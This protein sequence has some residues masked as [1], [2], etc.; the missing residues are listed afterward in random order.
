MTKVLKKDK[1]VNKRLKVAVIS[2]ITGGLGHYAFHLLRKLNKYVDYRYITY[3]QFDLIGEKVNRI[4]DP[5]FENKLT[6]QPKFFIDS[7]DGLESL[8]RVVSYIKNHKIDVVNIHIGTT[9]RKMIMFYTT[10]ILELKNY[11]IPIIYT[12]HDVDPFED[13]NLAFDG[14]VRNF[15][16]LGDCAI[17]GNDR[18]YDK[19]KNKF[20]KFN[21]RNTVI[22]RHGMYSLFN[23]NRYDFDTA[24]EFLK[25]PPDVKIIL[26]FGHLRP[27]KGLKYLIRAMREVVD[28]DR[29]VMLM[30]FSSLMYDK[31]IKSYAEEVKKLELETNIQLNLFYVPSDQ[32]EPIFKAANAVVLPYTSVSQSGVLQLAFVFKKPVIVTDLFYEAEI[33]DKKIGIVVPPKDPKA[34]SKA[35]LE[36]LSDKDKANDF[37][38]AGYE[39]AVKKCS[40]DVAA[41]KTYQLFLKAYYQN[42]KNKS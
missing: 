38:K 24:R 30:V 26:F 10:L 12:F 13:P 22:I 42:K 9:A 4:T 2:S 15:Y 25:I 37:G 19:L 35:I 36:I 11:R 6:Q 41:E 23:Q 39:Y 14:L 33:I 5:F 28:K 32:I 17:V 1:L 16:N 40:W 21:K 34:L 31:N 7:K 3:Q 8:L 20:P 18:E 27:N 29:K